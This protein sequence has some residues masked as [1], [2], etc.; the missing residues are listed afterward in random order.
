M[1]NRSYLYAL[2]EIPDGKKKVYPVGMCEFAYEIPLVHK[3]MMAG[4]PRIVRSAI[5]SQ[6]IGILADRAGAEER[7]LAF[8]HK[9]AEG[10]VADRDDFDFEVEEMEEF[11][12]KAPKSKYLLL[13]AGEIFDMSG[14]ELADE[15][16]VALKQIGEDAAKAERAVAGKEKAWLKKLG[17]EWQEQVGMGSWSKD[18]YF[19][20]SPPR[21]KKAA[22]KPA[23]KPAKK[24]AA[25]KAKAKPKKR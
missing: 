12:A 5:W 25:A 8:V 7:M 3:L 6:E 17:A 2:D 18:L 24:P 22:A 21:K 15:C 13:E 4:N 11:L 1:S 9:L 19:S 16:A 20:F 10:K 23:K 14:N